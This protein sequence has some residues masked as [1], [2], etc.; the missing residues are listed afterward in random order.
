M[1]TLLW[2]NNSVEQGSYWKIFGGPMCWMT[3]R[4]GIIRSCQA[5]FVMVCQR[6]NN[7]EV[8]D[9]FGCHDVTII[10]GT[11][12]EHRFN[13]LEKRIWILEREN[14]QFDHKQ[15]L[16]WF[17]KVS[18]ELFVMQKALSNVVLVYIIFDTYF[19]MSC[20]S[21]FGENLST[22]YVIL[23]KGISFWSGHYFVSWQE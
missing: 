12:P 9:R 17:L 19:S 4:E 15:F 16:F 13:S 20:E 2:R 14:L 11:F 23:K 3:F 8:S 21:V 1:D 10:E 22:L 18:W 5:W 6:G 7:S